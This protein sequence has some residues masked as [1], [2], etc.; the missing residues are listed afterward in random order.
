MFSHLV[1][2]DI[3]TLRFL[4]QIL[5]VLLEVPNASLSV[6][7][8]AAE[9]Y[10]TL[11]ERQYS[12]QEIFGHILET[13]VKTQSSAGKFSSHEKFMSLIK[14]YL[15]KLMYHFPALQYFKYYMNLL[16]AGNVRNELLLF[17]AHATCALFEIY[18][19]EYEEMEVARQQVHKLLHHWP[20]LVKHSAR[21]TETRAVIY[22]IYS[23]VDF[24]AL[25]EHKSKV[26]YL[27]FLYG[28]NRL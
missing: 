25:V 28:I 9:L 21:N 10:V 8:S 18:S 17:T 11:A 6:C 13:F 27:D 16:N 15:Q 5:L 2:T 20:K 23:A 26:S 4:E 7:S 3:F 24:A 1:S 19:E 12:K 14:V 22:G